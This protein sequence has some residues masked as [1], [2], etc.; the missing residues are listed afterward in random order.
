MST[1]AGNMNRSRGCLTRIQR[2]ERVHIAQAY[3][4]GGRNQ[5]TKQTKL[6]LQAMRAAQRRGVDPYNS[7]NAQAA[8][9][10]CVWRLAK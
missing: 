8:M 4:L 3:R 10:R 1:H 6:A 2:Y 7:A 5:M 9:Y